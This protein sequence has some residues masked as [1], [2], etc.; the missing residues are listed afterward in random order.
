M[1]NKIIYSILFF[2]MGLISCDDWLDVSPKSEI[3]AE[4]L[5]ETEAG[6]KD[7]LIGIYIGMT[8][9]KSYGENLSWGAIEFL[10][11]QY[12]APNGEYGQLQK[13]NY[14]H[15]SSKA[16]ID[17]IWAKQYNLISEINFL[18]ESL[19]KNPGK[20]NPTVFNVI[21]GEALALRAMCHFDLIRLFAKGNL[22]NNK[23]A[24]DEPCV[25]YVTRY[26]KVVTGQK[27]YRE[28]L[29]LLHKDIE[30]ALKCLVSDPLYPEPVERP[31]DYEDVTK[32]QPFFEGTYY[33][34]RETRMSYPAVLLLNSRVYLWEGDEVNALVYAEKLINAFKKYVADESHEWA[35]ESNFVAA[36]KTDNA[37]DFVF[38]GELL[39]ALDVTKL[40]EYLEFAYSISKHG[41]QNYDRL[42]QPFM[43][44]QNIYD[45]STGEANSDLRYNNW[46]E[47]IQELKGKWTIK[48]KKTKG[49]R[50]TN[51]IPLMRIS[52]AYLIAAECMLETN[53]GKAI[54][55]MNFLKEKRKISENYYLSK[56]ITKENLEKAILKEYRKE[57]GQ[58]GQL[59]F[60]YKRLGLKT[61]DGIQ[62]V[63]A[64]MGDQ[65]YQLP[66]P[67]VEQDLGQRQ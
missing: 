57:F 63:K 20:L 7:A 1:K 25:P 36:G 17:D 58:E 56:D 3:K 52:E 38:M 30:D 9:M 59:F 13:Y 26:T 19:D 53:K 50:F 48:I 67:V 27:S 54:E 23:A 55:Y 41:N 46:F 37:K 35:A 33:K 62:Y 32:N 47:D 24:L 61:F 66:Y 65:Q 2:A 49:D 29:G 16:L 51:V 21:K 45:F 15:N 6:F 43:F 40:S 8:D 44:V 64:D 60:C 10:A 4:K 39:F 42:V 34:G 14:K 11:A 31:V 22:A 28:T 18:L 12:Q 5:Y